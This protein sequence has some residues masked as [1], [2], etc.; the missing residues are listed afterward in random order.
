MGGP[1][2]AETYYFFPSESSADDYNL[3]GDCSHNNSNS[4]HSLNELNKLFTNNNQSCSHKYEMREIVKLI[5]KVTFKETL[6]I[7]DPKLLTITRKYHETKRS[8]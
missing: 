4:S 7:I 1:H 2:N 5:L 6:N 3:K 8:L